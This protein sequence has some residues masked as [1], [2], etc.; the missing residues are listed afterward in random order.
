MKLIRPELAEQHL[1]KFEDVLEFNNRVNE[2]NYMIDVYRAIANLIGGYKSEYVYIE[3]A[4]IKL[5]KKY[6]PERSNLMTKLEFSKL[7][8]DSP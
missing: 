2:A 7:I 8:R 3:D 4:W 5:F 6:D 1:D